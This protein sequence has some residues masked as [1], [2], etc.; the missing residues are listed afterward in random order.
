MLPQFHRRRD[1]RMAV[2]TSVPLGI[3]TAIGVAAH[4]IPQEV[5]DVAIRS[6]PATAGAGAAQRRLGASGIV[7]LVAHATVAVVPES[8]PSCSR[9]HLPA[10]AYRDVGSTPISIGA[11][12]ANAFRQV[13][14]IAAG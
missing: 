14:L 5:G 12:S 6:R 2:L 9:F 1:H 7:L 3:N 8:A 10:C 4:E 11:R 13:F